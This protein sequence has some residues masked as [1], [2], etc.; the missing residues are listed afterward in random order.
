MDDI[1][2]ITKQK[3]SWAAQKTSY[4]GAK[5][6]DKTKYYGGKAYGKVH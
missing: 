3:A 2:N 1:I 4:Y 6:V 5:A